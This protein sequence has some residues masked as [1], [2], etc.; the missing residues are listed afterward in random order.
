M[1]VPRCMLALLWAAGMP[2]ETARAAKSPG[3]TCG[4]MNLQ[5]QR[6]HSNGRPTTC[7]EMCRLCFLITFRSKEQRSQWLLSPLL[8]PHLGHSCGFHRL[9]ETLR[10][11]PQVPLAQNKHAAESQAVLMYLKDLEG[12]HLN[13]NP[14]A[15]RAL[16]QC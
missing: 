8:N 4:A 12:L 15:T 13:P 5:R 7:A 14:D 11:T 9:E 16:A 10:V 1:E 6:P 2:L 3:R